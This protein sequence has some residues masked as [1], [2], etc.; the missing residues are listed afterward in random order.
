[1]IRRQRIRKGCK[2]RGE[3]SDSI[4]HQ[5]TQLRAFTHEENVLW[6]KARDNFDEFPSFINGYVWCVI[7]Q[8]ELLCLLSQSY[9][10]G[11][12][13]FAEGI[14]AFIFI[15]FLFSRAFFSKWHAP[16]RSILENSKLL[17]SWTSAPTSW[18]KFFPAKTFLK[19]FP[20]NSLSAA[21]THSHDW[22]ESARQH[23]FIY[24]LFRFFFIRRGFNGCWTSDEICD[25]QLVKHI[26]NFACF[27]DSFNM[28]F[29][30]PPSGLL[31]EMTIIYS[32][33]WIN[34]CQWFSDDADEKYDELA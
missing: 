29:E 31:N 7:I 14:V 17:H 26:S 4:F 24:L 16:R 1:M 12:M 5:T 21:R 15:F 11:F 10:L 32:R 30:N 22:Q 19:L 2:R 27:C 3:A 25:T 23:C 18:H 33:R 34:R 8:H 6:P 20:T 28:C 9:I 13:S